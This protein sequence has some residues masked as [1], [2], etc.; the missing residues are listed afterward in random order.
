MKKEFLF[1]GQRHRIERRGNVRENNK[2]M[3]DNEK[4]SKERRK[5]ASGNEWEEKLLSDFLHS[6]IQ[7][8]SAINEVYLGLPSNYCQFHYRFFFYSSLPLLSSSFHINFLFI[9]LTIIFSHFSQYFIS[10]ISCF[11]L[12]FFFFLLSRMSFIQNVYQNSKMVTYK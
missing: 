2:R 6:N 9:Y 10:N 11:F 1:L 4:R 12:S 8:E 5:S 7:S 3:N